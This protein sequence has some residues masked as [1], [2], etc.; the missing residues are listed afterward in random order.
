MKTTKA[1]ARNILI[2]QVRH[3]ACE[4]Y[5]LSSEI[6]QFGTMD[7]AESKLKD[8]PGMIDTMR[9]AA[10]EVQQGRFNKALELTDEINISI[11]QQNLEEAEVS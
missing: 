3:V 10:W 2:N 11:G 7:K 5:I 1:I 9:K 4:L 8:L 6:E